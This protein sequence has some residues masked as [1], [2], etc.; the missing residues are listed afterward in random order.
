MFKLIITA[1]PFII[2]DF[3]LDIE[4]VSIEEMIVWIEKRLPELFGRLSEHPPGPLPCQG[5]IAVLPSEESLCSL[6][7][8]GHKLN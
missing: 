2:V 7:A 8:L 4:P 6:R 1:Y 3:N 5:N